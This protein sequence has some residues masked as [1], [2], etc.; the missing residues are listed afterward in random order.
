MTSGVSSTRIQAGSS[1]SIERN[2][3]LREHVRRK[4]QKQEHVRQ[5]H[6]QITISPWGKTKT[7]CL[8]MHR[9]LLARQHIQRRKKLRLESL[10][11]QI[12]ILI[13]LPSRK[14]PLKA[15]LELSKKYVFLRTEMRR[16]ITPWSSNGF[17]QAHRECQQ[18]L[19]W[20]LS[21]TSSNLPHRPCPN[22]NLL[23]SA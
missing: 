9:Q 10:Q 6:N 8:L 20:L 12:Q 16:G 5:H 18:S 11:I 3:A 23:H 1:C 7:L 2:V 22:P 14:H 17:K 19:T 15:T 21:V 13:K 4:T